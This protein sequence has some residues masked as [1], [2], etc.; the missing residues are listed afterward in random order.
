MKISKI[1]CCSQNN[2]YNNINITEKFKNGMYSDTTRK[3]NKHGI[4]PYHFF[5]GPNYGLSG[6]TFVLWRYSRTTL[7][8]GLEYLLNNI[9]PNT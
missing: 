5:M 7:S 6:Y 8:I 2:N 9:H 3:F 1:C 4:Q